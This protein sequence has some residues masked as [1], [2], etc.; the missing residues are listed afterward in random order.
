MDI[1]AA[2]GWLC[3]SQW[4]SEADPPEFVQPGAEQK[5]CFEQTYKRLRGAPSRASA[6]VIPC[7]TKSAN[8]GVCGNA[9]TSKPVTLVRK[10]AAIE[11]IET[12]WPTRGIILWLCRHTRQLRAPRIRTYPQGTPGWVAVHSSATTLCQKRAQRSLRLAPSSTRSAAGIEPTLPW[13]RHPCTSSI[14]R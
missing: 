3:R 1:W 11:K 8:V 9:A 13:T 14:L 12:K 10:D 6:A 7:A 4:V 5:H 2:Y